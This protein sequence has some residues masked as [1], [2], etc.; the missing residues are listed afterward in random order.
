MFQII[1]LEIIKYNY[2]NNPKNSIIFL[3]VFF[4]IFLPLLSSSVFILIINCSASSLLSKFDK[5]PKK[6]LK[7][8]YLE[9]ICMVSLQVNLKS[10]SLQVTWKKAAP[11]SVQRNQ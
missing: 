7:L 2:I 10:L 9:D 8:L 11:S 1:F 5:Q 3:D 6:L 4:P